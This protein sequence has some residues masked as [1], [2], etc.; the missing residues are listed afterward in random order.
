MNTD[1]DVS[2]KDAN[3]L[4][5]RYIGEPDVIGRT[6][7]RFYREKCHTAYIK[8]HRHI[9]QE[10]Y[11]EVYINVGADCVQQP[12]LVHN[13]DVYTIASDVGA[14]IKNIPNMAMIT[15]TSVEAFTKLW[16]IIDRRVLIEK[17]GYTW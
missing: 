4:T 5:V 13:D 11:V 1:N 9:G 8:L 12:S 16:Q 6:R 10:P 15:R 7:M 3:K 17:R 14:F 2:L